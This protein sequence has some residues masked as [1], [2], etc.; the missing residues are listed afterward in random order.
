MRD[1]DE[2]D[3]LVDRLA[4]RRYGYL[5]VCVI[6]N[7]LNRRSSLTRHLQEGEVIA[8]ILRHSRENTI[9]RTQGNSVK[10]H[11]PG[12][13]GVLHKGNLIALTA[14][15][16]GGSI[17][18][19]LD[20]SVRLFCRFVPTEKRFTLHMTHDSVQNW[21]RHERRPSIVQV[22]HR[23]TPRRFTPGAADIDSHFMFLLKAYEW[24]FFRDKF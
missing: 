23:L 19:M 20:R 9:A 3:A 22:Q 14:K 11:I 8:G 12:T 18:H 7:D 10:G 21:L 2:F 6:G 16:R 15:Q 1:G 5:P 24:V 17:V 4:Q 13:G